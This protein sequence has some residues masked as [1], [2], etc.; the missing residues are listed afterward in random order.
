MPLTVAQVRAAITSNPWTKDFRHLE[1]FPTS[2]LK[3]YS[4]KD[5]LVKAVKPHDRIKYWNIVPG[6]RVRIIGDKG[7]QVLEVSKINKLSNRVYLKGSSTS[8][9]REGGLKNVD[10]SRCQLFI[11]DFE[12]PPKGKATEP[13][14]LPVFATRVGT[15]KPHWQ[16]RGARYEWDRFAA[17]T[18]PRL[19]GKTK[20]SDRIRIPW[21]KR[22]ER[23][24]YEPTLYTAKAED[25][26]EVTYKP[27]AL[28]SDT[29]ATVPK[30]NQENDY[31]QSVFDPEKRAPDAAAPM[32]L[33]LQ[34][35]L[36]N[37]HSRA[38][39]QARWQAA[40]AR[41]REMLAEYVQRELKDLKGRTRR[42]ARAEA[43][44]KWRER[45]AADLQEEKKRRWIHRGGEAALVRRKERKERKERKREERLRNLVLKEGPNQI[46]PR[47]SSVA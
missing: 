5:M 46:I 12:F 4:F 47:E 39:K 38:K 6:D 41:R 32:E 18:T 24:K 37:P 7:G 29:S 40:L 2:Y 25:V 19:P 21:P 11:G 22:P 15:S 23:P 1:A 42:E 28:P 44:W 27:F 26:M 14:T 34:D 36:S 33:H 35:E 13:R 10:Y 30:E 16:P 8:S 20:I 31:I 9:A 3:R 17:G 43:V 45:L